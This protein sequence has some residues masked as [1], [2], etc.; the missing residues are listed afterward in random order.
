MNTILQGLI[1]SLSLIGINSI[2]LIIGIKYQTN[3]KA[4][5]AMIKQGGL[6]Y[7]FVFL[8]VLI[9][10]MGLDSG[11]IV[12]AAPGAICILFE[13]KNAVVIYKDIKVL[14]K[15]KKA[16]KAYGVIMPSRD[17]REKDRIVQSD[18]YK[19]AKSKAGK[20]ANAR[21]DEEK[22]RLKNANALM[23][24]FMTIA[25]DSTADK[26]VDSLIYGNLNAAEYSF[27]EFKDLNGVE[28]KLQDVY[29]TGTFV[30]TAPIKELITK[31]SFSIQ[32]LENHCN[33]FLVGDVLIGMKE[34]EVVVNND[35]GIKICG[36]IDGD[37]RLGLK[38]D[39]EI[40]A[41]G[42]YI[43]PIDGLD[44][45]KIGLKEV[46]SSS[47]QKIVFKLFSDKM[48]DLHKCELIILDS[49]IWVAGKGYEIKKK[50][51][52]QNEAV[53]QENVERVAGKTKKEKDIVKTKNEKKD[54]SNV[55][56][57]RNK[58]VPASK[59]ISKKK[60]VIYLDNAIASLLLK[61]VSDE[62]V[63]KAVKNKFSFVLEL[64]DD[65]LTF[66]Y[67]CDENK[68]II[69]IKERH[70]MYISDDFGLIGVSEFAGGILKTAL[71]KQNSQTEQLP[72]VAVNLWAMVSKTLEKC[73]LENIFDKLDDECGI[74][75]RCKSSG[76]NKIDVKTEIVSGKDRPDLMCVSAITGGKVKARPYDDEF[77][78]R[79]MEEMNQL[80]NSDIDD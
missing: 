57:T 63:N 50:V 32:N 72:Q 39:G 67:T 53:M 33:G 55:K 21:Y 27:K 69:K 56:T 15:E 11:E 58:K 54:I 45:G 43:V 60:R 62:L 44:A 46:H 18:S 12:M 74:M 6:G 24:T 31:I 17:D 80:I 28:K 71:V 47:S 5:P 51:T 75:I 52:A 22:E 30:Y 3:S 76:E 70:E 25:K 40:V 16:Y 35:E 26:F 34:K 68:T 66:D 42:Y 77:H 65:P 8:G 9:S 64:I 79:M 14:N 1:I 73:Y 13:I 48:V 37:I 20:S 49:N 36:H 4:A 23:N 78:D 41:D 61:N 10:E 59:S 7:A 38:F 19:E 29:S 2:F